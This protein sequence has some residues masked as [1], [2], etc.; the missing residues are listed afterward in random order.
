[1]HLLCDPLFT[2]FTTKYSAELE[3]APSPPQKNKQTNKQKT[4]TESLSSQN[5]SK[6]NG[7]WANHQALC[8][9]YSHD[10][11]CYRCRYC[12]PR[13][14]FASGSTSYRPSYSKDMSI[15]SHCS[16]GMRS[17][18]FDYEAQLWV[19]KTL[20]TDRQLF[21]ILLFL[22]FGFRT[23]VSTLQC[24][25]LGQWIVALYLEFIYVWMCYPG[26][27]NS[28]T[29]QEIDIIQSTF[30]VASCFWS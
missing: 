4:A 30:T 15:Y 7:E 28:C 23:L 27:E 21:F 24:F 6:A 3:D 25:P 26:A 22:Y 2:S 13:R 11:E 8:S 9:W 20:H 19:N 14:V 18:H 29:N 17:R 10:C 12:S 16:F 1:M 5:Q